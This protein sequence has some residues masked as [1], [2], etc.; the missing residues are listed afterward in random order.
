MSFNDFKDQALRTESKI[1]VA[2]FNR[3]ALLSLLALADAAGNLLDM[4]KKNIYYGKPIDADSVED[5]R[6]QARASLNNIHTMFG[7]TK[8]N[9][10][11]DPRVLHGVIG[12]FTESTELI[13][14][15]MDTVNYGAELDEVNLM[16][17]IGDDQWYNAILVDALGLNM[18][19]VQETVIN[20]LK[21]RYPDKF[22][23]EKAIDR[24]LNAERVILE[25]GHAAQEASA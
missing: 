7:G 6:Q 15:I 13:H 22:D 18:E 19:D 2:Q 8:D 21:A 9:L 4:A 3:R 20:K 16:E 1:P 14:A 24:D 10:K 5:Y 12:K 23:S 25:E 11:I 17:E